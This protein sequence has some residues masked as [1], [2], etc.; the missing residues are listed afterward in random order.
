MDRAPAKA[1]PVFAAS[2]AAALGLFL[3]AGLPFAGPLSLLTP[4]PVA[5]CYLHS[6]LPGLAAALAGALFV[7][8]PEHQDSRLVALLF[9][10]L[11]AS[12]LVLGELLRRGWGPEATLALGVAGVLASSCGV[13]LLH[14]AAQG[15]SPAA[16][17]QAL[18]EQTMAEVGRNL[19]ELGYGAADVEPMLE[20]MRAMLP[21]VLAT[22]V[23]AL[24]GLNLALA[25]RLFGR[26]GAQLAEWPP[27]RLWRL[28]DAL[29]FVA[30]GAGLAML[31][32]VGPSRLIGANLLAVAAVFY[33]I[34]GLAISAFFLERHRV[35]RP[36]R[37][38]AYVLMA[39]WHHLSLGVAVVGLLD[40]WVDF[41][42]LREAAAKEAES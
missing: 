8:L 34:Q 1:L 31:A 9:L 42:R 2:L 25:R 11:A 40:L 20:G 32:N 18:S 30:I 36:L 12:G 15:Q 16:L 17:A 23:G 7:S 39:A 38:A 19:K 14:A 24:F 10:E 35:P 33:F 41:R 29:V 13:F 21:A 28:P 6:R 3:A 5:Y 22:S 37:L 27:F 4:L 26:L